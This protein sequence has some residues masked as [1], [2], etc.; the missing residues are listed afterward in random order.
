MKCQSQDW[1][2]QRRYRIDLLRQAAGRWKS[3]RE[4]RLR[5]RDIGQA[6]E[7]RE[8]LEWD[9]TFAA[10]LNKFGNFTSLNN[11][12]A[13]GEKKLVTQLLVTQKRL[14]NAA[15]AAFSEYEAK[16]SIALV[17]RTVDDFA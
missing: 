6:I 11:M 1:R 4:D 7:K 3:D 2:E 14:S 13:E 16:E 9:H 12:E 8:Y 5:V 15:H 10:N 17:L